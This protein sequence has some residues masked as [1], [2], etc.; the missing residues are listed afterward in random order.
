MKIERVNI[1]IPRELNRHKPNLNNEVMEIHSH[2]R[3][4][5]VYKMDKI[6]LNGVP[7]DILVMFNNKNIK[8][9]KN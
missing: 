1:V 6:E 2:V 4:G 3:I 5:G 9:V 7:E 8:Y